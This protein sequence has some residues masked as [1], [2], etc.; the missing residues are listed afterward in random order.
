MSVTVLNANEVHGRGTTVLGMQ[1]KMHNVQK[2][3]TMVSYV[4]IS[5]DQ[6]SF[7]QVEAWVVTLCSSEKHRCFGGTYHLHLQRRR[8]SQA[9]PTASFLLVSCSAY[10][11]NMKMEPMFLWNVGF[12]LNCVTTHKTVQ[13]PD[14]RTSN[15]TSWSTYFL[16]YA[17]DGRD[18]GARGFS[19]SASVV[20]ISLCPLA[21]VNQK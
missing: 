1:R 10:S 3:L 13:S 11:L 12:L 17:T 18:D 2:T 4:T 16:S 19:L 5:M 15:P 6:G 20:Y 7:W 9:L 21:G 14:V 8:I